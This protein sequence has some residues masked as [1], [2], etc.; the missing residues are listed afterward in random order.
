METLRKENICFD[1]DCEN[2]TEFG[3]IYCDRH[4]SMYLEQAGNDEIDVRDIPN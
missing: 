2:I 3:T 4:Y 1:T